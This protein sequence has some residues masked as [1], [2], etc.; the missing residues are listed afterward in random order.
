MDD[1]D[2]RAVRESVD[3]TLEEFCGA[4]LR[5]ARAR[6]D[7]MELER[8]VAGFVSGGGKRLRP[9]L[10]VLGWYAAGGQG[11]PPRAVCR[12][13]AALELFHAFALIHDDVMDD[14]D[15]RRDHPTVHRA[16]AARR[17]GN[18][19]SAARRVGMGVAI[20]AGDL[21]LTWSDDLLRTA[22]L[23]AERLAEVWELVSAMRDEIVHGQFLDVTTPGP[24]ASVKAALEIA[25]Y[26]T[27]KYT[28]ERPLQLGAVLAGAPQRLRET[29][30]AYALP[31]GES[32]QLRDDLLGVF[33]DPSTTGK[34]VVDDLREG[35][36]TVLLALA[37]EHADGAQRA[38]LEQHIGRPG[39]EDDEADRVRHI[40]AAT[41][42][43]GR[44]EAM[45]R[46]RHDLAVKALE[47]A[48]I[49]LPVRTALRTLTDTAVRRAS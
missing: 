34:P 35:T 19:S 44:V 5:Q 1:L 20:L 3:R 25:R 29:L 6:P 38:L 28:F 33:G 12:V 31:A 39:L 40:L 49:P 8:A 11:P 48:V 36:P 22:G 47:A 4:R 9:V 26:K 32:F 15:R 41:G 43:P 30:S 27:A 37:F 45:I 18:D 24:R 13:A 42:A 14:S 2:L 16:F 23:P 46:E 21:A 10:C 17:G 7:G